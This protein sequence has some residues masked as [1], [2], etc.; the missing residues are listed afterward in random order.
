MSWLWKVASKVG[1]YTGYA[2]YRDVID[3]PAKVAAQAREYCNAVGK[4]LLNVG[5]GTSRSSVRAAVLGPTLWG[6]VNIDL[7]APDGPP[8]PNRV[9]YGDGTRVPYPDKYFG[10][11]IASHVLEHIDRPDLAVAE[12]RR[13]ADKMFV[14]VPVWWAP[15]TWLHPGHRWFIDGEHAWPIW[16][17]RRHLYLLPLSDRGYGSG[18]WKPSRMPARQSQPPMPSRTSPQRRRT[19][20]SPQTANRQVSATRKPS[21]RSASDSNRAYPSLPIPPPPGQSRNP[22][23]HEDPSYP[24]PATSPSRSSGRRGEQFARSDE[25][26]DPTTDL[27]SSESLAD[28]PPTN[29]PSE[30]S[31]FVNS[32]MVVSTRDSDTS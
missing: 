8:G 30:S 12:W 16:Q 31:S 29:E 18:P 11:V 6:D 26:L 5:A 1:L 25:T 10:A 32:L 3:R 28:S 21:G 14:I 27:M 4:P 22:S 9:T 17:H 15:H 20:R 23:W 24:D 13:V 2:Y 19:S 7:A